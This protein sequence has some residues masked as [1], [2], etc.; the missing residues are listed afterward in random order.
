MIRIY[1][2]SATTLKRL[3]ILTIILGGIAVGVGRLLTPSIADYREEIEQW[4]SQ[5]LG[6]RVTIGTLKGSWQGAAPKLILH[7]LALYSEG[8]YEPQIRFSEVHIAIGLIESLRQGRPAPS[9]ITIYAPKLNITRREDGTVSVAGLKEIDNQGDS[10]GAF[11]LPLRI[12]VQQGEITWQ[13]LA[14]D[15]PPL[16]LTGVELSLHNDGDRHQLKGS[17]VLPGKPSGRLQ[18][19]ADLQGQPGRGDDW[20]ADFYFRGSGLDLTRLLNRRIPEEYRFEQGLGDLELWSRWEKGRMTRLEGT[21]NWRQFGLSRAINGGSEIRSLDFDGLSGAFHWRQQQRGWRI[22]LADVEIKRLG[23]SWPKTRFTLV[24][25]Q[26]K[27]GKQQLTAGTSFARLEDLNAI[28]WL[29]PAASP[30]INETL[31]EILPH[32]DL[33]D[34][35]FRFRETDADPKWSAS[36]KAGSILTR[37]YK[38]AP[39]IDNLAF[40]WWMDQSQ[41]GLQLTSENIG[42]QFPGLFRAPLTIGRLNGRVDWQQ[43]SDGSWWLEAK[44]I[45]AD[46]HH[47]STESRLRLQIPSVPEESVFLDLQ[48]DFH[49]GDASAVSHYLPAGIMPPGVVE[50][51]D[52]SLLGGHVTEGSTLFRGKLRDFPFEKEPN[53][54]FEVFFAIENSGLD[55]LEGWPKLEKLSAKVRFLNS[56]MDAWAESGY[57]FDSRIRSLHCEIEDLAHGNRMRLNGEAEGPFSDNLRLLRESPLKDDFAPLVEGVSGEGEVRLALDISVPFNSDP[58]KLNGNLMFQDNL[59]RFE[60]Q[61]LTLEQA[62]GSLSFDQDHLYTDNLSGEI[63]GSKIALQVSTPKENQRATRV[64]ATGK[65]PSQTLAKRFPGLSLLRQLDGA[66]DWQLQVDIPHLAAGPDAP[67]PLVVSSNLVGVTVDLPQPTA[68]QPQQSL[69]FELSTD[70]SNKPQ[71]PLKISYGSLLDVALLLDSH[72]P[73]NLKL[74]GGDIQL[75]GTPAHLTQKSGLLIQAKLAELTLGPWLELFKA[76]GGGTTPPTIRQLDLELGRLLIKGAEFTP[77]K[78]SLKEKGDLLKG[79]VTSNRLKGKIEI[80]QNPHEKPLRL[81]LEQINIDFD[82]DA[83]PGSED[84]D[85]STDI[86][87]A[88]L[89]AVEAEIDTVFINGKS[90]GPLQLISKRTEEGWNIQSLTLESPRLQLTANGHWNKLARGGQETEINLS[91]ESPKLG[92]LLEDL[93]FARNIDDSA[94]VFDGRIW[95]LESPLGFNRHLLNGRVSM[96]VGKGTFLNVNPGVG[97]IFGLLNLGALQR[98]LTLD[99]SDVFAKGFAFDGIEGDF[100]L[101]GGDA[102]TSNFTIT[103]PSATTDITGR[104][105]LASED[106]D[107]LVTV[108]PRLSSS[109]TMAGAIAGGPVVG[110]ALYLAEKV[111][112][113]SFDRANKIQ[114][115]VTGPWDDPILER[116]ETNPPEVNGELPDD[117]LFK[118][119]RKINPAPSSEVEAEVK[120]PT[121]PEVAPEE[122]IPPSDG[123]EQKK[124]GFVSRLLDA[125]KPAEKSDE[126]D[127]LSDI[128][129]H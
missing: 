50:W 76:E 21:A 6:Q 127:P 42:L 106:F 56:R 55:Y 28:A 94:A 93:K 104:T 109:I 119:L 66:A 14:I 15:A 54:R 101:D 58:L 27:E 79:K 24:K 5:T 2:F 10:S 52:R 7:N 92:R 59:L 67:V 34:I 115:L 95:W 124:P 19:A 63:M 69:P 39:G 90:F 96:R 100:T 118:R 29:L 44:K 40:N 81:A 17:L 125:L 113:K 30:E 74:F 37:P 122:V 65:I 51:L 35:R 71:T 89:P 77:F 41:G 36:G 20:S 98:R 87:P 12:D 120:R 83:L 129:G 78:L 57:I 43:Q 72:D 49:D 123:K 22:D 33:Q 105:G 102:Y 61:D 13:D 97:R 25:R 103:G 60:R 108:T 121:A 16:T 111:V 48:T 128:P 75:G 99:F 73:D 126:H 114:Y 23:S 4:T 80:P 45:A 9:R 26:D 31:L 88:Q 84:E 46:N 32:G 53:G 62:G 18:L 91:L 3:L 110:A 112:G 70:L 68:K 11:L 64:V 47:I 82:P 117:H 107:Q 85:A 38:G 86:D 8:L 116:M 1:H